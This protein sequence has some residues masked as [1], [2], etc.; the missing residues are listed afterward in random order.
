MEW[1]EVKIPR[2]VSNDHT[3]VG[4]AGE[5]VVLESLDMKELKLYHMANNLVMPQTVKINGK[6][7]NFAISK[8][9]GFS[10]K[11]NLIACTYDAKWD[12]KCELYLITVFK[13]VNWLQVDKPYAFDMAEG[14]CAH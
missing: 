2:K 13:E 5:F 4:H 11:F 12:N 1:N 10:D 3:V 8:V 14:M 7:M 9:D 6:K